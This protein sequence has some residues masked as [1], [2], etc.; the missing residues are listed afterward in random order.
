MMMRVPAFVLRNETV[1]EYRAAS[2]RKALRKNFLWH[3][4]TRQ[5]PSGGTESGIM[6]RPVCSERME[7]LS[8]PKRVPGI[9]DRGTRLKWQKMLHLPDSATNWF[10]S[11][12]F[13]AVAFLVFA[14]GRPASVLPNS[15]RILHACKKICM[16][17][18]GYFGSCR[19]SL[20]A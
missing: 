5:K 11:K 16:A 17:T 4:A 15:S 1:A 19:Y 9:P 7:G 10:F 20:Y 6:R 12:P 18:V 13:S 2:G 8:R 3:A 14:A